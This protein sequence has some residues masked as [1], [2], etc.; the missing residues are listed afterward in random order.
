MD[1][2]DAFV[3]GISAVSGGG[4]TAVTKR[5]AEVLGDAV[6]LHFDD[7]DDTNVHP[8]YP[9]WFTDGADFDEFETPVFTKHLKTLK[10]GR[11]VMYPVGGVV[12]SPAKYIVVDAP[13]GR[14]HTKSGRFIDFMV[15]IDTPLDIAMA[16][17]ILRNIEREADWSPE[18]SIEYVK[19]EMTGYLTHARPIYEN[20]QDQMRHTSDLIIDGNLSVDDIVDIIGT[21]I[22]SRLAG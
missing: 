9:G 3:I 21:E 11:S 8:E 22:A 6:A 4:K 12:V 16:R 15:F 10:A 1:K 13:L 7:Y 17:R 19:D 5:L 18:E 14:A 20:H 2:D